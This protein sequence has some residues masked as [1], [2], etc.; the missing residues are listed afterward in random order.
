MDT[1]RL[2]R[3]GGTLLGALLFAVLAT[4]PAHAAITEIQPGD[5]AGAA[6]RPYNGP[7]NPIL[8]FT[9]GDG[10]PTVAKVAAALGYTGPV[11]DSHCTRVD[12]PAA[13][14]GTVFVDGVV[15]NY[16]FDPA[17]QSVYFN[18]NANA[19][20]MWVTAKGGPE[21]YVF[22]Y[23]YDVDPADGVPDGEMEDFALRSPAVGGGQPAGLSHFD[24][25]FREPPPTIAKTAT[26]SWTRYHDWQIA[27][28]ASRDSIR[29]FD[30]DS[31]EVDYT[32][33]ATRTPWG[34]YTVAGVI[35]ISDVLDRGFTVDSV[36]D[37]I[38]FH[39]D[40]S[41]PKTLFQPGVFPGSSLVC[42]PVDD[43]T[44]VIHRCTYSITLSSKVYGFVPG[45]GVNAASAQLSL[46]G[47]TMVIATTAAFSFPADPVAQFG[48]SMSVDDTMVAGAPDH[49]F[50]DSGTWTY[51]H[52][53]GC[54]GNG[55][56]NPNT[57]TGTW[58]TGPAT[59]AQ[60]MANEAVQVTCETVTVS[61]TAR[62]FYDVDYAWTADKKIV[63][64]PQDVTEEDKD[65]HCSPITSGIHNGNY[66][67]DDITVILNSGT[68]Y[69]TEYQ[70][71]A[72][73][74][75]AMESGWKVEGVITV[76]W[77]SGTSP[78]F[79]GDPSDVLHFAAGLP[80]TQAAVVDNCVRN[81]A[82]H[83]LT[84]DYRAVLDAKRDGTNW[85][86][87]DRPHVC[88]DGDGMVE[89]CAVPGS[90]TYK[91]SAAFVFGAPTTSTDECV[92]ISDLFNDGGLNIGPSFG[93]LVD[94]N[95]C[96]ST[97]LYVTGEVEPGKNLT[98]HAD[99]YPGTLE[100]FVANQ[101][102]F[103]V[104]NVL[105]LLSNDTQTSS[106]SG[107][108]IG[109]YVADLCDQGCTLTQGYW[110]THSKYGPAPYDETW[111]AIGE[112]TLFFNSGRSWYR[113]FWTPPKGGDAYL[114]LAHQY[115]AARLS[116]EAGASAP[117]EVA[118]ALSQAEAL[119]DAVG[120]RFNTTQSRTART[121]ATV[122][123]D[124]NN[125]V[126]GPGHCSEAPV[127]TVMMMK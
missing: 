9:G 118:S 8:H 29:M 80:A 23:T 127:R 58:G 54:P 91:G 43:A 39:D 126:I 20:I 103:Q 83:Q 6:T 24:F 61:K 28:D 116:I 74:S 97:T 49:T 102:L 47:N 82:A 59:T 71:G 44:D 123:D 73:R 55:G 18:W 12:P 57:V 109:V 36:A 70:L 40:P 86:E 105:S 101:C 68:W 56:N 81:D 45:G 32:I 114:Q 25:C 35:E 19:P 10:N 77:P 67:C 112:D 64:R 115:M 89:A 26:G 121:L 119:F 88:Y 50:N 7:A 66:A 46:G 85:A 27:K 96:G 37:S 52:A 34:T 113:T 78:V 30:G 11:D 4:G 38:V 13:G 75:A 111:A 21:A 22:A 3:T 117:P 72:S 104:P 125:G 63:V 76:G 84:C 79:S 94:G 14:G 110:K 17:T 98:I 15:F 2:R 93:W 62:T 1:R 120:N 16:E 87:I 106:T 124:Y 92:A 69:A 122:L 65:L 100:Q 48:A 107:A 53:F 33:T 95:V 60:A 99:W 90:S 41:N 42:A 5:L 31:H 108:G 51:S